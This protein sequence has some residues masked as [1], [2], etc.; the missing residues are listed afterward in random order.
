MLLKMPYRV[1]LKRGEFT[2]SQRN[3][4][5]VPYKI[6]YPVDHNEGKIP[7]II[8]SHGFGGS[9]D[10][11]AFISR[12][13]A[14]Q[15]YI[16]VHITHKGSDSSLWEGK[17]GHPWDILRKTKITLKLITERAYDIPFVLDQLEHL[18]KSD[19][20]IG[21]FMDMS[22]IGMSGHSLGALTTQAMAG[23]RIS[24][25]NGGLLD[26]HEKRFSCAIAYSPVPFSHL[27]SASMEEIYGSI[28][29]PVFYMTGTKDNS[30]MT[31][32]I[33]YEHRLS[34]WKNSVHPERYLQVLEGGDHMIYNGTRG[35]LAENPKREEHEGLI[36][37]AV[38]AFWQTYLKDDDNARAWLM[39]RYV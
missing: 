31:A 13:I 25:G 19:S 10:G 15:G 36:M 37:E 5:E 27:S 32:S 24:D 6:Y 29:M 8:W 9:R 17:N 4:R 3:G 30:P 38:L 23:M 34:V 21:R 14:A 20:D 18:S 39:A 16:I 22:R 26:M 7:V 1:L 2:D 33:D 11:A 35:K 12:H 28:S